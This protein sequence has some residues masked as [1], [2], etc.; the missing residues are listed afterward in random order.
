MCDIR[1]CTYGG[2]ACDEQNTVFCASVG[3]SRR[4]LKMSSQHPCYFKIH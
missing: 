3:L 2:P 1:F 4:P